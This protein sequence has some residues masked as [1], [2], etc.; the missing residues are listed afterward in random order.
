MVARTHVLEKRARDVRR[1]LAALGR[2]ETFVRE[3]RDE[4]A[5]LVAKIT[6]L[7]I[8]STKRAMDRHDYRLSLDDRVRRSLANTARF[9]HD[10]GMIDSFPELSK[11]VES[12]WLPSRG[13]E[14][15]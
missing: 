15:R 8:E 5:R 13:G 6:G 3:H 7:P 12:V 11:A 4:T 14:H 9:L 1:F 10:Q 2:A